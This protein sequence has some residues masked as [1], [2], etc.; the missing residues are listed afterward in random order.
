MYARLDGRDN[1]VTIGVLTLRVSHNALIISK[2]QMNETTLIGIHG[3]K[4]DLTVTTLGARSRRERKLLNL[5]PATVLVSLDIYDDGI[6]ELE[7]AA[8]QRTI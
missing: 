7:P 2:S 5:L 4:G 1:H 6:V 3:S 8:Q